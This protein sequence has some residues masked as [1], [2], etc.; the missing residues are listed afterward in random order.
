M[1]S[2]YFNIDTVDAGDVYVP[3]FYETSV[4]SATILGFDELATYTFVVFSDGT[5]KIINNST[6]CRFREHWKYWKLVC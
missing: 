6:L 5:T 2:P 4:V 1:K 3:T